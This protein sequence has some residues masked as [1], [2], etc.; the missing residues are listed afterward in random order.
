MMH[1]T[2][3]D[4]P[5]PEELRTKLSQYIASIDDTLQPELKFAISARERIEAEIKEYQELKDFLSILIKHPGDRETLVD[6]GHKMVYCKA[7]FSIDSDSK[8]FVSVGHGFHVEF[9]L[10]EA[11]KYIERRVKHL[12]SNELP[13]KEDKVKSVAAHIEHALSLLAEM[14]NEIKNIESRI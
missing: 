10:E 3:E 1:R 5:S 6:L 14:G 4:N 11:V 9:T 13:I 2:D 12:Q 8:I 7:K